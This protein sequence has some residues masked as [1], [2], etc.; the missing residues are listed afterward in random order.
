MFK[1]VK[2]EEFAR[3]NAATGPQAKTSRAKATRAI[4]AGSGSGSVERSRGRKKRKT[5]ASATAKAALTVNPVVPEIQITFCE[6][7]MMGAMKNTITAKKLNDPP[8]SA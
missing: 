7:S 2:I 5:N 6:A 4:T 8:M 1:P 3:W